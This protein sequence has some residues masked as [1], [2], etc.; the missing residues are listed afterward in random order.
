MAMRHLAMA[1]AAMALGAC[2]TGTGPIDGQ[3]ASWWRTTEALSNDSME[4]RDTG[5]PGYDRAAAYTAERFARAG[6]APAGDN[7]TYFQRITFDEVEVIGEG[8]SFSVTYA[9][10]AARALAFLREISVTPTWN[11]P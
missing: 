2:A 8:T 3:T 4:G 1:C 7:G 10:G 11:L 9:N 6:L 5:S